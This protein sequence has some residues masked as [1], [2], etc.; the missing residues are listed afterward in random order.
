MALTYEE[1]YCSAAGEFSRTAH[2]ILSGIADYLNINT[3]A[4]D[5]QHH[6]GQKQLS[7]KIFLNP[8]VG[9]SSFSIQLERR[10]LTQTKIVLYDITGRVI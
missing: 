1:M 8:A 4:R 6:V 2:A 7:A 5:Y 10:D 3:L 9:N